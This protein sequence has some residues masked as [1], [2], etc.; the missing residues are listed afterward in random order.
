M[1]FPDFFY[2]RQADDLT[3]FYQFDT[4][5]IGTALD[6]G[7]DS[8]SPGASVDIPDVF[9]AYDDMARKYASQRDVANQEYVDNLKAAMQPRRTGIGETLATA[10]L[11]FG[12]PLLGK[13]IGG[14]Q[15][16]GQGGQ[17]GQVAVQEL[18]KRLDSDWELQQKQRAALAAAAREDVKVLDRAILDLPE[19]KLGLQGQMAVNEASNNAIFNRQEK[20]EDKRFEHDKVLLGMRE[21]KGTKLSPS[22]IEGGAQLIE[23]QYQR[24]GITITPEIKTAIR[25][26]LGTGERGA[27]DALRRQGGAVGALTS[28]RNDTMTPLPGQRPNSKNF[29]E[30]SEITSRANI[31]LKMIGDLQ[32]AISSNDI[33]VIRSSYNA[34][35]Q[36]ANQLDG[37]GK[38][39]T[40]REVNIILGRIGESLDAASNLGDFRVKFYSSMAGSD[41]LAALNQYAA[42]TRFK[43]DAIRHTNQYQPIFGTS[44]DEITKNYASMQQPQDKLSLIQSLRQQANENRR[45]IEGLTGG[46]Q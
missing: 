22:A 41:P 15:L 39:L 4:P 5:S 46:R 3:D 19:K 18:D 26:S 10:L 20:L 17:M 40:E 45:I 13:A 16:G 23:Q 12:A 8:R 30:A 7:V 11:S 44:I 36:E 31:V 6:Y 35:L 38:A 43:A 29:T 33:E 37:F 24:E 32:S 21:P 14:N 25:E 1:G 27:M 28:L 34:V 2:G 42:Q 9:S